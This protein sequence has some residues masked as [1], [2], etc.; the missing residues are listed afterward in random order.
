LYTIDFKIFNVGAGKTQCWKTLAEARTLRGDKTKYIDINPKS[1]KT[2]ELYG[3]ISMATRE[4][5]DGLLSKVMRDLG[6]IPDEKPKWIILDGDLDANWIES[7]NSVM[8]DN[9]MLTLASNERIPLKSHMRLIFE[10]RDLRFAT[11]ATVS[12][13]GILYISTDDGTQWNSLIQSWM[14]KLSGASEVVLDKLK[15][16]FTTYVRPTLK[17]MIKNVAPVVSLQDMN[18]VQTLLY[19]LNGILT[20]QL[21]AMEP[22]QPIDSIEKAFIFAMIWSMGSALTTTDDGTDNRKLFS[23]W[24][25]SEWRNIKLPTQYTIFDYWYDPTSNSFELWSKSPFL[26]SDMMA[27]DPSVPMASV[28]VPTPETCSVTYW[29]KILVAGRHPVMLAG[30][31]GTGN[32]IV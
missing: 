2:E 10:I 23:D 22:N 3:Y 16:C 30:L 27:Y 19:M 15:T 17:W 8:D 7:M 14:K 11:P 1:V 29:M 24:W 13:A 28:T 26:S 31:S 20:P 5:K 18:F 21:L 32:V 12:R 25:R 6:E 9:K 4:W